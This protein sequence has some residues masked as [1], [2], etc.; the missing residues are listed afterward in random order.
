MNFL[1]L[2]GE[3]PKDRPSDEIIFDSISECDDVWGNLL[4]AMMNKNDYGEVWYYNGPYREH[5]LA[6][7]LV[8]R[9]IPNFETY[10]TDFVPNVIFA[11]G[12]FM[13]YNTV[14]Y[15][16]SKA[17]IMAYGA[18]RRYLLQSGF[19]DYNIILQDSPEQVEVCKSRFPNALITLF[20]KPAPDNLFYPHPEIETEYDI[21]FI[22]NGSQDFKGHSMVYT[23]VPPWFNLLN[24]G[25][26]PRNFKYPSNITSYR[27]LKSDMPEHIAKCKMGIVAVSAE[28]DSCPRVIAEMLACGLPIVVLDTVRFWKDKY[29]NS[30]TDS[31]SPWATGELATR[32]NFWTVVEYVLNN[33]DKYNPRKY[34]EE[35]LSLEIAAKFLRDKINEV[36]I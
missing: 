18:G 32:D 21:C 29:I 9:W 24:L 7:N 35:N 28:R 3:V 31:K 13:E 34:Y 30:V 16:Y 25:N 15:R 27:V 20:I 8:E 26:N 14:L 11:R 4:Y 33:L 1:M 23:T 22:A 17:I 6:S 2:R 5:K 12:A 19:N 10:K 36:S